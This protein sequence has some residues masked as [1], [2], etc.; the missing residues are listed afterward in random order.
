MQF[1]WLS[2]LWKPPL[3]VFVCTWK[4]TG[5][6]YDKTLAVDPALLLLASYCTTNPEALWSK[7]FSL[8]SSQRQSLITAAVEQRFP[9]HSQLK[10]LILSVNFC[11]GEAVCQTIKKSI[12]LLSEETALRWNINVNI[13]L[14]M[15]W[16]SSY[17]RFH[18]VIPWFLPRVNLACLMVILFNV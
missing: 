17:G 9:Q 16:T 1:T 12:S 2:H 10:M 8:D 4:T 6:Y 15:M 14:I 7:S 11:V 18:Q 5:L 13:F 3:K